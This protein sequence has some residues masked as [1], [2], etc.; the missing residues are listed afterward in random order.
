MGQSN[1][2]PFIQPNSRYLGEMT[3]AEAASYLSGSGVPNYSTVRITDRDNS[4]YYSLDG[5]LYNGVAPAIELKEW[6]GDGSIKQITLNFNPD[7]VILVRYDSNSVFMVMPAAW[8]GKPASFGVAESH[9]AL[10]DLK[11]DKNVLSV[12]ASRNTLGVKFVALCIADNGSNC[13]YSGSYAGNGVAGRKISTPFKAAAVFVKRDN[14]YSCFFRTRD[15]STAYPTDAATSANKITGLAD[16]GFTVDGSADVNEAATT[17][18]SGGEAYD[19]IAF[20][21]C[22]YFSIKSWIGNGAS[23]TITFPFN[24]LFLLIKSGNTSSPQAAVICNT[25][26]PTKIKPVS[27]SAAVDSVVSLSSNT[28]ALT[29]NALV[30]ASGDRYLSLAV[31]AGGYL[32]TPRQTQTRTFYQVGTSGGA[33]CTTNNTDFTA[34]K[35]G[36]WTVEFVWMPN[37]DMGANTHTYLMSLCQAAASGQQMFAIDNYLLHNDIYLWF[38]ESGSSRTLE[39]GI[40]NVS[41]PKHFMIGF[42]GTSEI[43]IYLNGTKLKSLSCPITMVDAATPANVKFAIGC[44]RSTADARV[45]IAVG[46]RLSLVRL[47]AG[48]V[49]TDA[50]AQ[51]RYKREM[52]GDYSYADVDYLEEWDARNIIGT[53]WYASKKSTNN[54]TLHANDT[55]LS[56]TV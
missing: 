54:A 56:L 1:A 10:G 20:K 14:S 22:E 49:C 32:A 38:G 12:A 44:C 5:G 34:L 47:Y 27:V 8:R 7:A 4:L 23:R 33:I 9:G 6:T 11:I 26:E 31:K 42:D 51:A 43:Y 13:F 3:Y 45:N 17:A 25:V 37:G 16:D 18:G 48:N 29:N 19:F 52:L 24:P 40:Y 2:G 15:L 35:T 50:N 55:T 46:E 39:T 21:D 41:G 53:T 36:G 28:I 30:N